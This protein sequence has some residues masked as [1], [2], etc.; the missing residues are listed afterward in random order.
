MRKKEKKYRI[1]TTA[2]AKEI[3]KEYLKQADL[4]KV[5]KFGL[6]EI[7]D[8]YDIYRVPLKS[9]NGDKEEKMGMVRR[10]KESPKVS[11]SYQL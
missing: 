4:E 10:K 8:R 2:Q 5:I 7:D 1:K 6:P 3:A 9:L 11:R